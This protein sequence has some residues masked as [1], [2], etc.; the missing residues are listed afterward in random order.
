MGLKG[1]YQLLIVSESMR[2]Y[3]DQLIR[4]LEL[5]TEPLITVKTMA[6]VML[7]RGA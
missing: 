1:I 2:A 6:L 5:Y 7:H 3:F 4:P